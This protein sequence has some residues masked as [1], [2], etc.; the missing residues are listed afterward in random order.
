[1]KIAVI[2]RHELLNS[3]SSNLRDQIANLLVIARCTQRLENFPVIAFLLQLNF[4][5][6]RFYN[7]ARHLRGDEVR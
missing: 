6:G 7:D 1:M 4:A 3:G 5:S 2:V